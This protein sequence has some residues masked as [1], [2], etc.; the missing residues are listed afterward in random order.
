LNEI[1]T[2]YQLNAAMLIVFWW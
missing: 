1:A 2:R